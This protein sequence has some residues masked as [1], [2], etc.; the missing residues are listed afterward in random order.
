MY[1]VNYIQQ[2]DMESNGK[3]CNKY[4]NFIS[5]SGVVL[6]GGVGTNGQHAFHQFFH[7]G[8]SIVPVDFIISKYHH[9]NDDKMQ[10]LL[11]ANCLGQA[12][13]LMQGKS[14]EDEYLE[15][16][17]FSNHRILNTPQK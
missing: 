9:Y 16:S 15:H 4:N 11:L 1:F 13:A 14:N 2:L 6:W 10:N 3:S 5:D 12:Q 8:S 7:Q 17:K